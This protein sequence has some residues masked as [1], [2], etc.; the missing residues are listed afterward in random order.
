MNQFTSVH[1]VKDIKQLLKDALTLKESPYSLQDLGKNKTL[2][3]VF[4]NPSLR[5]R[6]ST[7]KAALNLGMNVMVMNMDKEGWALETQDGVVMNGTTVEHI[8]EAA[9]V[10][11]QY[12]DILG[13]RSFPKLVNRDEDY[14]EDFFNK[15][16]KYC[17]V[18][19]VSLESATRHPLQS[20][21]DLITIKETWKGDAKPKVVLAWAP[22]IKALPQAVPNSFAE[23]MCKAQADGMIDFTIAQPKGYELN[24]DFTPG[25]HITHNLDE[26]LAGADYIYVKNWSSYKDYGKVLTYP[27]GW[28][29]NNEKLKDTND[30][31]VMHCL[32]V[33]RDLELSAEILDGPNSLV[34][35]EAGNRLWAAQ[36]VLKQMLESLS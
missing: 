33:R 28:M 20:L 25:A 35:H 2:G 12:C 30:A 7:Q 13:L 6:L 18:P 34:I 14:N 26:A 36:A 16:I 3:L 22:H 21:A 23:W 10:M 9:A 4:L 1:D 32:P 17:G 19:V 15:F 27:E 5:T 31:K 24:E 29:L 11:G 8:R